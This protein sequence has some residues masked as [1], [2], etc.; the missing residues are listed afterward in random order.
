MPKPKPIINPSFSAKIKAFFDPGTVDILKLALALRLSLILFVWCFHS[1]I[2]FNTSGPRLNYFYREAGFTLGN[3][4]SAWDGQWYLSIAETGYENLDTTLPLQKYMFFPL[5][6]LIIS[7]FNKFIHN[8]FISATI[9][10]WIF[11]LA[12]T[13][14]LYKFTLKICNQKIATNTCIL[15]LIQPASIFYISIYTESLFL[16][17]T[18]CSLYFAYQRQWLFAGIL[19]TLSSL[20]KIQGILLVIPIILLG[21]KHQSKSGDNKPLIGSITTTALITLGLLLFMSYSH[22]NSNNFLSTF[23]ASKYFYNRTPSFINALQSIESSISSLH[24]LPIHSYLYSK[25]DTIIIT[26]YILLLIPLHRILKKPDLFLYAV[27]ITI[28]PLLSGK[29]TSVLRY[30]SLSFPHLIY[31]SHLTTNYSITFRLLFQFVFIALLTLF[32]LLYIN[33]Y[34]VA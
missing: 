5:Y 2:P 7:V 26:I 32:S 30:Y 15:F 3:L 19:G 14:M 33:W 20:T 8:S 34:W 31:F 11:S 22:Y 9:I 1:L 16:F 4:L 23:Y 21:I 13:I 18:I 6:P 25:I 24:Q 10:S 12:S 27:A 29:T 28:F 17:L